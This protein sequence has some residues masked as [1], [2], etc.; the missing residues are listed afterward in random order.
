MIRNKVLIGICLA[1]FAVRGL[2]QTSP[3]GT[4][5]AV[6]T[7]GEFAGNV[8]TNEVLKLSYQLPGHWQTKHGSALA[9]G[10]I[11]LFVAVERTDKPLKG[12][13]LVSADDVNAYNSPPLDLRSYS[14][15][16]SRAL[17]KKPGTTVIREAYPLTFAGHMFYRAD[18]KQE[19]PNTGSYKAFL[20]TKIRGYYTSWAFVASTP[21]ELNEFVSSLNRLSFGVSSAA[22]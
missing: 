19:S 22:H 11:I 20:C 17:F 16:V 5:P 1:M 12:G 21:D 2:A 10:A 15:K 14:Q 3:G 4:P 9:T 7:S 18:F 8:Y 13:V 6:L